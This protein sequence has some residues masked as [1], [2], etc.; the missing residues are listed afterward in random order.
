PNAIVRV[1]TQAGSFGFA[2]IL[3]S[4]DGEP[5]ER[6]AQSY[7]FCDFAANGLNN[8]WANFRLEENESIAKKPV[9]IAGEAADFPKIKVAASWPKAIDPAIAEQP[10]LHPLTGE[11]GP[12]IFRSGA[13]TCGG[14]DF[15]AASVINRSGAAKVL[16]IYDFSDDSGL[17]TFVGVSAGCGPTTLTSQGMVIVS[18]SKARCV[19]N[20]PF[21]TTLAMAPA[22]RRLNEDWAIFFDRDI[23]TQLR[24]AAINLGAPGDRRD[25]EGTLWLGY[26]RPV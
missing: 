15:S 22:H 21:R 1:P 10:R 24:R 5:G 23:D 13:G 8:G 9:L 11:S 4:H 6:I 14:F 20:F 19:C 2:A 25:D 12:R 18:E 16:A 3:N 26:P 7:L 17:R